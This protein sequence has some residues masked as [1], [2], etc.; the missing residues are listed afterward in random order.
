MTSEANSF[1]LQPEFLQDRIRWWL[2]AR[3]L[4]VTIFLGATALTHLRIDSDPG[5]PLK[6]VAS[7]TVAAYLFSLASAFLL[8]RIPHLDRFALLQIT[9]DIFLISIA[10]LLTGGL[11]SPMAV[12]YN[13]AIIGAALL[14]LRRGAYMAA[15]FASL[16]YGALMNLIYYQALPVALLFEPRAAGPGFGVVYQIAANIASFFSIAFLSSL[17]VE[18]IARTER[19]LELSETTRQRIEALQTALVQNLESGV[20]TTDNEGGIESAN[21][22]VE[23]ILGR[24]AEEILGRSIVE[25]F[26]VLRPPVGSK[27]VFGPSL[28]PTELLYAPGFDGVQKILRCTSAPLADT[29]QNP[30]GMLFIL[31][32]ITTL[33]NLVQ[34]TAREEEPVSLAASSVVA[35]TPSV[36]GLVGQSRAMEQVSQLLHKAARTESTILL[37]G[38]SGTGKELAA[39]GI[40]SLS[41]RAHKPMIVVNCAAIPE[42]LIESELF[43]HVRG[44]FTGAIADRRGLFRAADGGTIFLDEIGDLPLPLQVKLLRVLQERSF[45]PVGAQ[46]QAVVDVRIIAATNR[47][48]EAEVAVGRFREDLFYRLNVIRIEMPPLR[49]RREDLPALIQHFL[50]RFSESLRKPADKI[51]A[52]AMRR[53]LSYSYPGNIRELE[54]IIEHA[55]ALSTGEVITEE[56]LP[57][58]LLRNGQATG[59]GGEARPKDSQSAID[60]MTARGSNLDTELE[61]VE[62]RFL[63][64]ALR[65]AGGIRKKAAEILGINYRSLR[66]RLSK[67]GYSDIGSKDLPE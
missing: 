22:A 19:A 55:V 50:G 56:D 8:P 41:D 6:E 66:H 64:E 53:L 32:D 28:I 15:T 61:E 40:H 30:I 4:I 59:E 35:K 5:F 42:N 21:R 1:A 20:L 38:E 51:S 7:L 31:Q 9:S 36:A 34:Q 25:I 67:Y 57:E 44:S 65:R 13:L 33:V 52:E 24:Q 17:L 62:R 60:W 43:G 54:N 16:I 10:V 46:S 14:R 39:R 18:R 23:S 29:Y 45:T 37:T 47:D 12:W 49:D 63:D 26:P 3:V 2:L 11:R 48:L 58:V 27:R